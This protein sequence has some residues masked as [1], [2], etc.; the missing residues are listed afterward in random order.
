LF[1]YLYGA[2][3]QT[4]RGGRKGFTVFAFEVLTF[5]VA[6]IVR[7]HAGWPPALTFGAVFV[8][9]SGVKA[10]L[11]FQALTSGRGPTAEIVRAV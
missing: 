10:V 5:V 8:V 11:I 6:D 3:E 1:T 9:L 4:R 7:L 2:T